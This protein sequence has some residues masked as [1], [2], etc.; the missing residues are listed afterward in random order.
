[1]IKSGDRPEGAVDGPITAA[2]G[3]LLLGNWALEVDTSR[4]LWVAPE[5]KFEGPLIPVA[6]GTVLYS[7]GEGALICASDVNASAGASVAV[8]RPELPGSSPELGA[9]VLFDGLRLPGSATLDSD[10]AVN[11]NAEGSSEPQTFEPGRVSAIEKDGKLQ[12]LQ[13]DSLSL[14]HISEPT[15]PY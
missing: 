4:I 11:F 1:M 12:V 14:I 5:M 3:V 15:R 2:G 13:G 9:V 6:D 10:G 7:N 8:V